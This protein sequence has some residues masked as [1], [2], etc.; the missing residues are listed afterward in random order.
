MFTTQNIPI[1][2]LLVGCISLFAGLS[3]GGFSI[4][5]YAIPKI[6]TFPRVMSGLVGAALIGTATWLYV[7]PP[8]APAPTPTA[9]EVA[10]ATALPSATFTASPSNTP[11]ALPSTTATTGPG[12]PTAIP[13]TVTPIAPDPTNP[14]GALRYYFDMVT[15]R[16]NYGDAWAEFMTKKYQKAAYSNDYVGYG[17]Y[18]NT[19]QKVTIDSIQVTQRPDTS[20]DCNVSLTLYMTSGLQSPLTTTYHLVFDSTNRR[21]MFDTP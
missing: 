11:T 9:S 7:R 20:V 3:G 6:T 18:W 4:K 1:I 8:S 15:L 5:D 21:W 16:R 2:L 10:T 12:T 17:N 14:A 19:I 13:P